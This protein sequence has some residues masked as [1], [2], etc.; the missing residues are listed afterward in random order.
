MSVNGR[1]RD[2]HGIGFAYAEELQRAVF[3]EFLPKLGCKC[4]LTLG[5]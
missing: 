1:E 5:I 4:R 3:L 2:G